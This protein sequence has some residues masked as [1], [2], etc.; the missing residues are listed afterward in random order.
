M[1]TQNFFLHLRIRPKFTTTWHGLFVLFIFLGLLSSHVSAQTESI[2]SPPFQSIHFNN[3]DAEYYDINPAIN[4]IEQDALG[5][6]WIGT[7]DGLEKFD[8]ISFTHFNVSSDTQNSLSNNWVKDIYSDSQDRLWVSTRGGAD[9]YHRETNSFKRLSDISDFPDDVNIEQIIELPNGL[10]W[11]ISRLQ[12]VY[13]LNPRSMKVEHID[14]QNATYGLPE[15]SILM[16]AVLGERVLLALRENETMYEYRMDTN[17]FVSF[18]ALNR[19]LN[20]VNPLFFYADKLE[21]LWLVDKTQGVLQLNIGQQTVTPLPEIVKVCG[22][23]LTGLTS[24]NNGTLWI[25]SEDGLCGYLP[26]QNKAHLY[27]QENYR[28]SGLIDN[29]V[30][31]LFQDNSHTIWV[32]TMGGVS[33]WNPNQRL[34]DHINSRSSGKSILNNDVVTS[35]AYDASR[36]VHYI[37]TF[38]GGVSVINSQDKSVSYLNSQTLPSLTDQRIM[39]LYVSDDTRLWIATFNSGV[40]IYDPESETV[41]NI[42][43]IDDEPNSLRSNA[44]SKIKSLA[45]GEMAFASFGGGLSILSKDGNY[46]HF[47]TDTQSSLLTIESDR[48]LDVIEDETG[49]LWVATVTGGLSVIDRFESKVVSLT[50]NADAERFIQSNNIFVLTQTDDFI[51]AG[52]QE[53]GLIKIDKNTFDI[54]AIDASLNV[55]YINKSNGLASNSIYGVLSDDH[56]TLWISHT[57]GLSSISADGVITNYLPSN[58]VQAEDFTA[59]A[60]Y[61]DSKGQLFFGGSNGF[62]V[63]GDNQR[64]LHIHRPPLRLDSLSI[65]NKP[66]PIFEALN[67]DGEIELHYRDSFVSFEV[68]VLDFIAPIKNKIEYRLEGL[69]EDFIELRSGN[70]ISFS[71]IPDGRYI[72]NIRGYNALGVMTQNELSMPILVHPPFWRNNIALL[73]YLSIFSALVYY[74][75]SRYHS[76]ITRQ[77]EF[78]QEL[79]EQVYERTAELSLSNEK[80]AEAVNEAKVAQNEA[81]KAAHAKSIFLAT[82]SHEIRTPMNNIMGMGELLLNTKMNNVQKKYTLS[83]YRSS[84]L[85]LELLNNIL[86]F[87][88]ID[89]SKIELENT[90]FGFTDAIEELVSQFAARA[91][92]NNIELG[93]YISP[94][95]PSHFHG[96]LTRIRQIV[97]NLLTNALKFTT[98]GFVK[99]EIHYIENKVVILI[100]DSGIGIAKENYSKVFEPFMQAEASTTRRFGGTGLGL[101]ITQQL[102]HLMGGEIQ[103]ES[104]IDQ[105]TTFT[106]TL[107]L[108]VI[109]MPKVETIANLP[110]HFNICLNDNKAVANCKNVLERCKANFTVFNKFDPAGEYL[111]E[112]IFI[113][114]EAYIEDKAL[115]RF[116]DENENKIVFYHANN[117]DFERLSEYDVP[118][119]SAPI[120]KQ[121]IVEASHQLTQPLKQFAAKENNVLDFGKRYSFD[122]KILIVEDVKT[123]Q[124]LAETVLAQLG[125][126]HINVAKN[127]YE[128]LQQSLK[129]YYDLI[130]MDYQM[131]IMDGVEACKKIKQQNIHGESPK[132][133]AFTADD[134]DTSKIKWANTE[135][136]GYMTK[137]FRVEQILTVLQQHLAHKLVE[138]P[139][140]DSFD[141][142][143]SAGL[144]SVDYSE[145]TLLDHVTLSSL[146]EAQAVAG[147][148]LIEKVV[149]IFTADANQ[150]LSEIRSAA[151]EPDLNSI[152]TFAHALKSM[153]ANVGAKQFFSMASELENLCQNDNK[154]SHLNQMIE[155][156]EACLV[157]TINE[158]NEV[159]G[160]EFVNS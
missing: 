51:W 106:V 1:L 104:K 21:N 123:N 111:S 6:I 42:Y 139:K 16:A 152:A 25:K 53:S 89:A 60:F 110:Q 107:P 153:S 36:D 131:P 133:I 5:Y 149:E 129:E 122:A 103:L 54:H 105:G 126:M 91:Y 68:S 160:L 132:I 61:K 71:S 158:Y 14:T 28:R 95:C 147:N 108:K 57:Q 87:S 26:K 29:R 112:S 59:G 12:G 73:I 97:S 43:A 119:I 47:N 115:S 17:T 8:G 4:V 44:V 114:D 58:G 143:S 76:K 37:G 30:T 45:S 155:T 92:A 67:D 113:I 84:Q 32:G 78:N 137:P 101:N 22:N 20:E 31:A 145:Y 141:N 19:Q 38:G 34:F 99:T 63:V 156:L 83:F 18:Q 64:N 48:V 81:E 85:L 11:F 52:T 69:H 35:F 15:S 140:A 93:I 128:A 82:M 66:L 124:V 144:V 27:K 157:D 2:F 96:D 90:T 127:G 88:K 146:Q 109:S 33:Y 138:L 80:L 116:F 159:I 65:L 102:V 72:L 150:T 134:T 39:N 70:A 3:I 117:A 23:N 86:D 79:Q 7:Q 151:L 148:N 100:K 125:V 74:A 40:F 98:E 9:L 56:G 120:T 130:L 77:A 55:S 136:D 118:F 10:L 121:C 154:V 62:I 46:T 75:Y 50:K 24:D 13:S 49:R 135:V 41:K 142:S 94:S